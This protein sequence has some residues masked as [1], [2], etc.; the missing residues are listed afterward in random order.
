MKIACIGN[1][2]NFL[3]NLTRHLRD[4]GLDVTLLLLKEYYL[5][6]PQADSFDQEYKLY[7]KQLKWYDKPFWKLTKEEI[8]KDIEDY[9]FIIGCDA[10]PAFL[11]KAGIKLNIFVPLGEDLY[12]LPF[13]K[14][15]QKIIGKSLKETYSN[16]IWYFRKRS[17]PKYQKKGIQNAD[18]VFM[19][20]TPKKFEKIFKKLGI[21]KQR[22]KIDCP[23][24][25]TPIFN[26]QSI[27]NYYHKSE[28]TSFFQ[29]I[30]RKY[31]Y[32]IF[33]HS[34]HSWKNIRN[35][36]SYKGNEKLIKGYYLFK[37]KY[38]D[39]K[40]CLVTCEYGPDISESKKLIKEYGLESDVIWL[41]KLNRKE[42]MIGISFADI[43]VG[44]LGEGWLSYG[45]VYEFMAMGVPVMHYR[46]DVQYKNLYPELYPMINANTENEIKNGLELLI[47][48]KQK[49]IEIGE[50]GRK[51]LQKYAIDQPIEQYLA[52]INEHLK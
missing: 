15:N 5:F 20:Q 3:F 49:C 38:P 47:N 29:Q 43:G 41:P 46:D 48:N 23:F 22:K 7:T 33:H 1:M 44:D 42:I 11:Y 37:K 16:I 28:M 25:Y 40:I 36:W 30:R 50:N 6:L 9:D 51:W 18:Y 34:R 45:T 31:D 8:K 14:V 35:K 4:R 26:P 24:I 52:I 39:E 12:G 21:I 2:N 13:R 19:N 27:K 17:Y 32:V 10:S